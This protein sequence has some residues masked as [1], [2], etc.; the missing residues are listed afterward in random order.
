MLSRY[1]AEEQRRM[2]QST[3]RV[4]RLRTQGR[5]LDRSLWGSRSNDILTRSY[6][7]WQSG[8]DQY[9]DR[10]ESLQVEIDREKEI[11]GKNS[12]DSE[13]YKTAEK[14]LKGLQQQLDST[15]ASAKSFGGAM[16]LTAVA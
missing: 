1:E 13:A 6:N 16:G 15:Q 12:T 2:S 7:E 9:A 8:K 3:R 11:M 5:R 10:L 14:N 4:E